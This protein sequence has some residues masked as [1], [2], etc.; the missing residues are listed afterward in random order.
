MRKITENIRIVQAHL[1][2]GCAHVDI[3]LCNNIYRSLCLIR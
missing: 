1:G 3:N 2:L